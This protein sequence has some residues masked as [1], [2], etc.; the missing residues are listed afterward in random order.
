MFGLTAL[1]CLCETFKT[2]LGRRVM[3]GGG[4]EERHRGGRKKEGRLQLTGN[5][6]PP[7]LLIYPFHNRSQQHSVSRL[8]PLAV[9]SEVS[10]VLLSP[11]TPHLLSHKNSPD[12]WSTTS[13]PSTH[14]NI[15]PES[16]RSSVQLCFSSN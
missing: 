3:R 2:Y 15:K 11:P 12:N 6:F 13:D 1:W 5:R 7:K 4:R 8:R 16:E 9:C 10:R 14:T